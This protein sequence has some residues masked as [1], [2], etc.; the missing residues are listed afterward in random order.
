METYAN[1]DRLTINIRKAD[2]DGAI[3]VTTIADGPGMG[4][5]VAE[6]VSSHVN[7]C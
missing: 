3:I 1:S 7:S 5:L 4:R 2:A 6:M